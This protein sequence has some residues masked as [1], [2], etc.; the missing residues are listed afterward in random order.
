MA[1]KQ[2]EEEIFE[3]PDVEDGEPIEEDLILK[4]GSEE[5]A[6]KENISGQNLDPDGAFEVFHGKK[7]ETLPSKGQCPS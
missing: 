4:P 6:D 3:T 2:Q 1:A 7:F 5:F